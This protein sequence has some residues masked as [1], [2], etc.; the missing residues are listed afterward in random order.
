MA[1]A[2]LYRGGFQYRAFSYARAVFVLDFLFAFAGIV[3]L[4]LVVRSLQMFVRQRQ[5]NLI[6]TLVVGQGPEAALCI[7]EIATALRLGTAIEW[8]KQHG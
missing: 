4:R 7:K 6:P 8:L 5:L 1:A 2:F 3:T